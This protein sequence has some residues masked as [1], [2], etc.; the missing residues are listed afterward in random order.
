MIT[1]TQLPKNQKIKLGILSKKLKFWKL[2][3]RGFQATIVIPLASLKVTGHIP[4]IPQAPYSRKRKITME[5]G[6]ENSWIGFWHSCI[7][8]VFYCYICA[9]NKV[10]KLI[11]C[12]NW[13]FMHYMPRHH[14]RF[15]GFAGFEIRGFWMRK[16]WN[17]WPPPLESAWLDEEEAMLAL[18][19]WVFLG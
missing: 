7:V 2:T 3:C 19:L 18:N 8:N 17:P 9:Y 12:F 15:L 6:E 13:S 11:T 14:V 4:I 16:N 5:V 10:C 1:H